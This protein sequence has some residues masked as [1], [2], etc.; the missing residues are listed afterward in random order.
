M[1]S[2]CIFICVLFS[3]TLYIA[4]VASFLE[5]SSLRPR[6]ISSNNV[7]KNHWQS[8][9]ASAIDDEESHH[10]DEDVADSREKKVRFRSRVAYCGTPFCG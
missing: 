3:F 9:F 7:S 5:V 4:V 8:L 10:L 2:Y 1:A 6:R